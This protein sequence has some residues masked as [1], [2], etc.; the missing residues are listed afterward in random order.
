VKKAKKYKTI[1]DELAADMLW[2]DRQKLKEAQ[3]K[4]LRNRPSLT[5][6]EFIELYKAVVKKMKEE[7]AK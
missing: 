4:A 3:A 5:Q 6:E 7:K 1:M 2:S